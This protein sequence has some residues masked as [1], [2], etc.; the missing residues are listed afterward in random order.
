MEEIVKQIDEFIQDYV[1]DSAIK[2]IV[3]NSNEKKWTIFYKS[4][5]LNFDEF[6]SFEEMVKWILVDQNQD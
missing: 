5:H 6:D 4:S 2:E 3:Y 1:E